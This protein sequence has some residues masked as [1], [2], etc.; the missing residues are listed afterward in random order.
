[1]NKSDNEKILLRLDQSAEPASKAI[2]DSNEPGVYGF[3]LRKGRLPIGQREFRA[4]TSTLLYLGK[5]KLGQM[6]RDAKEHL[7]DG[8]TGHSTLRRSLGA[9]LREQLNLKP[10][11]RSDSEKS[12]RRFTNFKFDSLGEKKLTSWMKNHL[13]VGFCPLKITELASREKSLIES[14]KPPLNLAHNRDNPC[15]HELEIKRKQCSNLARK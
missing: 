9:L 3:Y 5:T 1:M 12:E 15:L 13:S 14:I 6:A 10:C 7:A 4:C 2:P 8:G 11:P